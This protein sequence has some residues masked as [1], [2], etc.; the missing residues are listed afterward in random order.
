MKSIVKKFLLSKCKTITDWEVY[1]AKISLVK[2]NP[3]S[4]II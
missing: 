2:I 3:I 4:I 1:N